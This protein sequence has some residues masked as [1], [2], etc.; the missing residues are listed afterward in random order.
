[1]YDQN[2]G[3]SSD[4]RN[5]IDLLFGVTQVIDRSSLFQVN[6]TL[7]ESDGYMTDPY[8]IV[9]LVDDVSGETVP[10]AALARACTASTRRLCPTA[11][12]SPHLIAT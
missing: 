5:I 6:L 12:S 7:S 8:K 10:T 3:D 2:K 4:S 11:I 9:S 1:M